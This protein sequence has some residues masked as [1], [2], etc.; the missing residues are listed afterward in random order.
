MLEICI[1]SVAS[2]RAAADGGAD[3]VELCAAL[4][5]GGTTPSAGMIESVRA[6]FP[7]KLMVIIRPRGYEFL[8]SRDELGVMRRDIQVAREAGADG[9]V[10]GVLRADGTVDKEICRDLLEEVNGMDATFHRAF[11]MSRDLHESLAT[12]HALGIRRVLSSGGKA[13]VPSGA[14]ILRDLIASA[15]PGLVFMPGGGITPENLAHVLA[16]TGAREV[17][18]SARTGVT[19]AMQHRNFECSMGEFTRGDEYSWRSASVN[20]IRQCREI[21]DRQMDIIQ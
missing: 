7:G 16:T 21:L 2:A 14:R 12:L 11:D 20:A 1:D 17:H 18:L 3:R 8:Y 19:S 9:V 10:F 6:V 5:E 15:P 4:P 13:D